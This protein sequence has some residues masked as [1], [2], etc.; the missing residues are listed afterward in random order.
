MSCIFFSLHFLNNYICLYIYCSE[1]GETSTQVQ[2]T[3]RNDEEK[4]K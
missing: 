1:Q 2:K 4:K 3:N